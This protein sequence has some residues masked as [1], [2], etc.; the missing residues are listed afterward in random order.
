MTPN[1][2]PTS[3]SR[4][5]RALDRAV[6]ASAALPALHVKDGT[7]EALKWL[8]LVLMTGDHVNTYL[9]DGALPFLFKAGRL[10]MPI[11][12]FVIAYNLA[13]PGTLARGVYGRTL[14]RLTV[15]GAVAAAP[16]HFL[17]QTYAPW[18][19]L[20]IMFTLAV[21]ALIMLLIERAGRWDHA[22]AGVVF[23]VGGSLV[24]Y[25]WPAIMM[26]L[27]V[28]LYAK[29]PSWMAGLLALLGWAAL[30]FINDTHWALAAIPLIIAMSRLDLRVP[31]LRWAFYVYYPLH[32][33]L[34]AL[35]RVVH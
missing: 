24:D 26:G 12:V 6:H 18:W 14:L 23:F 29:R 3:N 5:L 7:V 20:N 13:R 11:F 25:F 19:P 28:W 30:W 16:L 22:A 9:L 2:R 17:Q 34:L 31:R 8:A 4:A 35:M 27:G 21:M 15:F 33:A 1:P 10:A 32:L